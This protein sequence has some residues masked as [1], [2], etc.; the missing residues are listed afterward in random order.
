MS[1]VENSPETSEQ[2]QNKP[3]RDER[4]RLLPGYS[5]NPGGRPKR[6]WLTDVW[7]EMLEE[8]LT[9]PDDRVAYKEATWRK[10][11]MGN[12]VSAMTTDRVVERTEGKLPT[13]VDITGN[14]NVTLSE[15]M[16]KA[17]EAV[18]GDSSESPMK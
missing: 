5:G 3:L 9:N 4:G 16:A 14:I 6:K 18:K 2:V 1:E 13:N 11:M 15:R 12:V 10:M 7:D 8:K 17:E